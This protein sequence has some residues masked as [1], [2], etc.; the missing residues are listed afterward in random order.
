MG[1]NSNGMG[2]KSKIDNP[3]RADGSQQQRP[4]WR[5]IESKTGCFRRR[6]K[7]RSHVFS[8]LT[9]YGV[10][11]FLGI[12]I[13]NKNVCDLCDNDSPITASNT[14]LHLRNM[15]VLGLICQ[16]VSETFN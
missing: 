14:E 3:C 4:N 6:S 1:C 7:S 10:L 5:Q 12:N 8:M 13:L 9:F 16:F 2:T 11:L 15:P